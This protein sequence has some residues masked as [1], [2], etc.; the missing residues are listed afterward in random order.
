[1]KMAKKPMNLLFLF[2]DQ[3]SKFI[4]GCYGNPYVHTPNLDRLAARGVRFNNAYCNNPI[5]V[6]SRA[7]MSIGDYGFR[8]SYWDNSFPY[9]AKE[10]SWGTRLVQNGYRVTTI[11]KLHYKDVFSTQSG[12]PDQRIPLHVR[13]GIGDLTHSIRDGSMVRPALRQ[14]ILDA[15]PGDSDYIHYD[16]KVT[17][18]SAQFLK[19]AGKNAGKP[20]CLF[21]GFVCPH[22]PWKV[23]PEIMKQYEPYDK[24]PRPVQWDEADRP[25][26]PALVKHRK[27]LC[28]E[29]MFSNEEMQKAVAAYYG[30]T[31]FVDSQIGIVLEALKKA[32][33]EDSTRI[34]YTDDHGDSVGD[35]GLFFKHTMY[36]GSVGIPMIMAGPDL[37]KGTVVD[38]CVSLL[39]V[40]PTVLDNFGIEPMEEDRKLPGKSLFQIIEGDRAER[41]IFAESHCIGFNDSVFMLRYRQYKYINYAG[42]YEPQ[43]F[44]LAA[45]PHECHDL[46]AD[47]EYQ[48]VRQRMHDELK[49]I[50]D[51]EALNQRAKKEQWDHMLAMGG[52]ARAMGQLMAYSP[53]PK[54]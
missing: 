9:A 23:P 29:E 4:T 12:F 45:D 49:K 47:L 17:E 1:M 21:V 30:M 38:T 53:T 26:H 37:P 6:P 27:E 40:F 31:T 54:V 25:M 36:E 35:H 10:D 33:L 41:P 43:L 20:F 42:G 7:S 46:A 14:V 50:A 34:L 22:F 52:K 16:R 13:D 28:L 15:G 11:G 48:E 51:P 39:D 44:D 5:C 19:D 32:G 8:H 18:L 2:T 3:H 24:L